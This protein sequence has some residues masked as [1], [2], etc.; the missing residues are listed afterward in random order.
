MEPTETQAENSEEAVRNAANIA[1]SISNQEVNIDTLLK[2][3]V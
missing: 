3:P 1:K 2:V